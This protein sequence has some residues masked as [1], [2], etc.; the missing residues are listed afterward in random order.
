MIVG[1]VDDGGFGGN[2]TCVGDHD[3]IVGEI[4]ERIRSIY[5]YEAT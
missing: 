2:L 4:R 1:V 3:I 5:I